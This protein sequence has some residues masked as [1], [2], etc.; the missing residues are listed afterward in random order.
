MSIASSLI[1]YSLCKGWD[2]VAW[3]WWKFRG[4]HIV[5]L[6][7]DRWKKIKEIFAVNAVRKFLLRSRSYGL[8]YMHGGGDWARVGRR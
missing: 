4:L 2:Y 8:R 1:R 3:P 6:D 7:T 5:S